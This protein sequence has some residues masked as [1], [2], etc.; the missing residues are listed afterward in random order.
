MFMHFSRATVRQADGLWS[1]D[2]DYLA[3]GETDN[4]RIAHVAWLTTYILY[5][6]LPQELSSDVPVHN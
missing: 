4:K 6:S 5:S 3:G 1:R 2:A